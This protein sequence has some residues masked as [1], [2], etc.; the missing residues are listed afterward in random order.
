MREQVCKS[1][2]MAVQKANMWDSRDAELRLSLV[3]ASSYHVTNIWNLDFKVKT[4]QRYRS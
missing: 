3:Q 4:D 1:E 2:A